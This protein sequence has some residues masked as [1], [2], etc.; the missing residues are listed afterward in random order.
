VTFSATGTSQP[1]TTVTFTQTGN[2]VIGLRAA[3][4]TDSAFASVPVSVGAATPSMVI[5]TN[6]YTSVVRGMPLNVYAYSK[7]QFGRRIDITPTVPG[8]RTM[9]WTTTDPNGSFQNISSTGENAQ[10]VSTSALTANATCKITAT[11]TNG[12]TGTATSG[13]LTIATNASPTSSS[14]LFSIAQSG[15][16]NSLT[17]TATVSNAES[18]Q[19]NSTYS[20]PAYPSA[21]ISY[22]WSVVSTPV[23]GALVLGVDGCA[24]ISGTVSKPGAYSVRLDVTDQAG[25]SASQT[26]LFYVDSAGA[27]TTAIALGSKSLHAGETVVY[28]QSFPRG[29]QTF[30]WQTSA[31]GGTSWQDLSGTTTNNGTYDYATLNYGPVTPADNGRQ[32]CLNLSISGSVLTGL[33]ATITVVDPIGGTI[34][35]G[36]NMSGGSLSVP[37]NAGNATFTV[38]RC[39]KSSGAASVTWSLA[40]INHRKNI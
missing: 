36:E 8:N 28:Q 23:G 14:G 11:G 4:A 12:R 27:V 1:A 34:R 30:Q 40:R 26:Q 31:D 32:F 39:G 9:N 13:N 10:F 22:Q 20:S 33:P 15:T 17:F 21:L 5:S 6:S 24:A 16:T 37:E 2:Y 35:I 3:G 18:T 38:R 29:A 19:W 25:A 7:D